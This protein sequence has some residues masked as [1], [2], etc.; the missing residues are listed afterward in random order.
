MRELVN[1]NAAKPRCDCGVPMVAMVGMDHD[2][3]VST[4]PVLESPRARGPSSPERAEQAEQ[5]HT[6]EWVAADGGGASSDHE[7]ARVRIYQ[8]RIQ[9]SRNFQGPVA[10]QGPTLADC[11]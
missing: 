1:G 3:S 5:I 4:F 11:G 8:I 7:I 10:L 6:L 9:E 2:S